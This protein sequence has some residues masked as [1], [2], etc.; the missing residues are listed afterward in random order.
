[1]AFGGVLTNDPETKLFFCTEKLLKIMEFDNLKKKV[2]CF[3]LNLYKV[4]DL[5]S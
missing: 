3:I 4:T 1:M 5:S 2:H